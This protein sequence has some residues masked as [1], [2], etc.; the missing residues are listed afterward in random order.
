MLMSFNCRN[1]LLLTGTPI[2]NTMAEVNLHYICPLYN[3]D[4]F[5]SYSLCVYIYAIYLSLCVYVS[6]LLVVGSPSFHHAYH[7]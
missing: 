2:Q 7:V 4:L 3:H 5:Y 6:V 1:R